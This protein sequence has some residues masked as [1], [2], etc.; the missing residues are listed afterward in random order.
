MY[1]SQYAVFG[2][3]DAEIA[4]VFQLL[5]CSVPLADCATRAAGAPFESVYIATLNWLFGAELTAPTHTVIDV[6]VS[7]WAGVTTRDPVIQLESAISCTLPTEARP[8][9]VLVPPGVGVF[10][11][12]GV[13]VGVDVG[14]L[15]INAVGVG[16]GV[17][18][19]VGG[20]LPEVVPLT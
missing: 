16:V 1:I 14:V 5:A 20:G 10:V 6:T 15:V 4:S 3:S 7:A 9:V 11:G 2:L 19:D 8:S 17:G 18:V 13:R 12:V